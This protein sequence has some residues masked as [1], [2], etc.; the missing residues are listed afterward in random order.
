MKNKSSKRILL[1]VFS[2]LVCAALSVCI[3]Y[4]PDKRYNCVVVSCPGLVNGGSY[5]VSACGQTQ[6]VTLA[7]LIYG[8]GMGGGMQ[9]GGGGFPGGGGGG[10]PGG[11]W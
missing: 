6:T 9:P 11:R 3:S 7:N 4:T 2:V 5:T 10:R 1:K 8:S